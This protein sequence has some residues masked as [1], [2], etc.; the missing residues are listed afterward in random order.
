M[1]KNFN[2]S[3][4]ND[5]Y[6]YFT[7]LILPLIKHFTY[8]KK[9]ENRNQIEFYVKKLNDEWYRNNLQE[10]ISETNK[11]DEFPPNLFSST[12][13]KSFFRQTWIWWM[14]SDN[15]YSL[16][17]EKNSVIAMEMSYQRI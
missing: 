4:I 15:L 13:N 1:K 9:T 5:N 17:I 10:I 6:Y 12:F 14:K 11:L 2:N 7:L 16:S 3:I 8:K